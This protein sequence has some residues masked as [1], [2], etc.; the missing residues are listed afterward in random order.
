M[1]FRVAT[2][3]DIPQIHAVRTAV[4]ENRLSDPNLITTDDYISF[5]TERGQGWVCEV[6]KRIVGFAVVDVWED[7][8]WALFLLPGYE[9]NGIGKELQRL[10]LDWFFTRGKDYIWLGTSPGTRAATFYRMTGWQEVGCHG[11]KEIKF[12]L[13]KENWMKRQAL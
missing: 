5:L 4:T 9:G 12:E 2:I 1:K 11:E 13:T 6:D 3:E 10:M 7:N 8:V